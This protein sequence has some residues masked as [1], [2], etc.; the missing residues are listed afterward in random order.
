MKNQ[1][2]KITIFVAFFGTGRIVLLAKMAK[3]L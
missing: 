2:Y 1:V 3:M